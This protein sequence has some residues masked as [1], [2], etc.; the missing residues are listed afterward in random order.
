MRRTLL[1]LAV[2]ATIALSASPAAARTIHWSGQ[3]WDVENSAGAVGPG[4]NHFSDDTRNV[5]VDGRGRLH[6]AITHRAG[7]WQCAEISSAHASGFGT[8][9]FRVEGDAETLD[10][11]IVL[12][13]FTWDNSPGEH[14]RELDIEWSRWGDASDQKTAGFTVQPYQHAG[15]RHR[16]LQPSA[17][18]VSDQVFTW[19]PASVAFGA[20]AVPGAEISRWTYRGPDVP[21]PGKAHV[22]LNFWLFRGDPP[23]NAQPAEIVIRSF[24]FRP[25]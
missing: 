4:P 5:W 17:A 10:P 8:Y 15:N 13:L 14:H 22:H 25:A 6:V 1:V 16:Y 23:T 24:T 2:L 19:R 18:P 21:A 11:N 9:R 3:A 12:G 20:Y 7:G